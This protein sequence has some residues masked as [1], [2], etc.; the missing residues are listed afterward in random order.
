MGEKLNLAHQEIV[1]KN[2]YVEQLALYPLKGAAA[3]HA[4]LLRITT[5]GFELTIWKGM[6][7]HEPI[8]DRG[9]VLL[10]PIDSEKKKGRT[11]QSA[12]QYTSQL[13]SPRLRLIQPDIKGD[14]SLVFTAPGMQTLSLSESSTEK[15]LQGGSVD[16]FDAT[17]HSNGFIDL[18]ENVSQWFSDFLNTSCRAVR[19]RQDT[20]FQNTSKYH[21]YTFPLRGADDAHLLLMNNASVEDLNT[22][23]NNSKQVPME[24]FRPNVVITGLPAYEEDILQ[25]VL[26]GNVSIT[27]IKPCIRCAVTMVDAETGERRTDGQPL[28]ELNTYRK[29]A[30]RGVAL[31]IYGAM[32]NQDQIGQERIISVGDEIKIVKTFSASLPF[33][34]K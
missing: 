5:T 27:I 10:R 32:L 15:A 30:N 1:K 26:I 13:Q 8:E 23:I 19:F 28:R 7:L 25:E 18:G 24:A 4:D 12:W 11:E 2:L 22:R 20:A 6:S 3:L 16:L 17:L 14:G 29:I 34:Q 9:I 33:H 21:Q 31:G